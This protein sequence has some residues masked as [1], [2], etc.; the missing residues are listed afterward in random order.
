MVKIILTYTSATKSTTVNTYKGGKNY[1][2]SHKKQPQNTTIIPKICDESAA[3]VIQ[4]MTSGE[5]A[6][7]HSLKNAGLY[8]FAIL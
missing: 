3:E 7:L 8:T 5:N 2:T 1:Y 4:K 6:S